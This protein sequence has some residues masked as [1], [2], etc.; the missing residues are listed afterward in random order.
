MMSF[1][2][3]DKIEEIRRKLTNPTILLPLELMDIRNN[4]IGFLKI[5]K[6]R[7]KTPNLDRFGIRWTVQNVALLKE[8]I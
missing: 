2:E 1:I 5:H 3:N 7:C 4:Y 8:H 6:V